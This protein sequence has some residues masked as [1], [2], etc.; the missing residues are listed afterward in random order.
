MKSNRVSFFLLPIFLL[1]ICRTLPAQQQY[2]ADGWRLFALARD[3]TVPIELGDL[4]YID[5]SLSDT[6]K[7]QRLR[8]GYLYLQ[9]AK[10]MDNTNSRIWHELYVLT[11]SQSINDVG[12]A[13]DILSQYA[14]MDPEDG[15]AVE[16]WIKYRMGS[17]SDQKKQVYF[18][19]S[20]MQYLRDYHYVYSKAMVM[21][22]DITLENNI[23]HSSTTE[24]GQRITGARDYFQE[25]FNISDLYNVE[26]LEKYLQLPAPPIE[27]GSEPMTPEQMQL[28]VEM[29]EEYQKIFRAMHWRLRLRNN[30]YD[31]QSAWNLIDT[32]M[33]YGR[34]QLAWEYFEHAFRLLAI[35]NDSGESGKDRQRIEN[36]LYH[37]QI[38]C[39]YLSQQYR[40]AIQIAEE[41]LR[42]EP[43]SLLLNGIKGMAIRKFD[44]QNESR[45]V[46]RNAAARV[47]EKLGTLGE[48]ESLRKRH[49]LA[50]FYCFI[51]PNPASALE[52]AGQVLSAQD[53]DISGR[54]VMAYAYAL[55][56][57]LDK[58]GELLENADTT[59]PV[60][61]LAWAQIHIA[62]GDN[63]SAL[64][65]LQ[66]ID[67]TRVGILAELVE[68]LTTQLQVEPPGDSQE[69]N[70]L[71][72][73]REKPDFIVSTFKSTFNDQDLS[74]PF[75][76]EKN[77]GCY[78]RLSND[79]LG[80]GDPIIVNILLT[81]LGKS[82][83]FLGPTGFLDPHVLITA[84]IRAISSRG[85]SNSNRA[86]HEQSEVVPL[87]H[88]Y[89]LQKRVLHPNTSNVITETLNIGPVREILENHPQQS[90]K[91][92]FRAILDP[93]KDANG[94]IVGKIPEIQPKPVTITRRGFVPSRQRMSAQYRFLSSGE[95]NERIKA[96][97]LLSALLREAQ[98]QQQ[99]QIKY[100][101][102]PV[103]DVKI[104]ELIGNN[105][106]DPD[107][108]V[109][110]WSAYALRSLPLKAND[111]ITQKLGN[112]LDDEQWFVRFMAAHTLNIVADMSDYLNW[113]IGVEQNQIVKQQ[114]QFLQNLPW[115]KIDISIE[116][117]EEQEAPAPEKQKNSI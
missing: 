14:M 45:E 56:G 79:L 109:R 71:Q 58:G 41:A 39:A 7:S 101:I 93:V 107:F 110:A 104:R 3:L 13:M 9:V 24:E 29:E 23:I 83:L 59:D 65:K 4:N 94:S 95:P 76:L 74:V 86:S 70:I 36:E 97:L 77:I 53:K 67:G 111:Q 68:Q 31:F 20:T 1:I 42:N 33:S 66:E 87:V 17:I 112:L 49:E 115:E 55:N 48:K 64:A 99:G 51:D 100:H 61:A 5:Q 18:L 73:V 37:K 89:L 91:I 52:Y 16:R 80:Y 114:A 57:M 117:P 30:P 88:H 26:A 60:V 32:L 103:S 102:R 35:G 27:E 46:L 105:L 25:A 12:R 21:L 108:R 47:I 2:P 15:L 34:Y 28:R 54:E 96:A 81:N 90:Y 72:P 116:L 11:T 6:Q 50:W 78:L 44:L 43:D 82:S 98:L 62:Q 75:E 8:Q 113:A 38:I 22:A 10:E 92:T 106:T 63:Q 19:N 84:E 85:G 69:E 40:I